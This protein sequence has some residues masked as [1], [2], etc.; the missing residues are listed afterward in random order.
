MADRDSI[1]MARALA[2]AWLGKGQ[3]S[4]N[5][6]VGAVVVQNGLIVG[7][8]FHKYAELKHAE[9]LAIDRAGEAARGATLYLNLEPCCHQGRTPP[10]CDLI[11]GSGIARIVVAISDPNPLVSGKGIRSLKAAGVEVSVG[12]MEAEA[13]KLNEAF[14]TYIT[15]HRPFVTL[16]AGVTLDGKIADSRGCSKWI[17]SEGS[18]QRVQQ[19]RFENDAVLVG[20][21]TILKDDPSLTDRSGHVRRRSLVRVV[22]DSRLRL[23]VSS[24]LIRGSSLDDIIVFCTEERDAQRERELRKAGINI[25]PAPVSG[26]KIPFD[27]VLEELGRRQI[28]SVLIEGGAEVNFEALQSGLV[29]K[30]VF[31]VAPKILGGLSS[32]PVFGGIGF[33]ELEQSVP[34]Q[35]ASVEN[36]G[37]DLMIEAYVR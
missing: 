37:P 8:G 23:P 19:L 20:I 32:L 27:F 3:T 6:M 28:I 14:E 4:P 21:G 25:I 22:L 1:Y 30:V 35:F 13:H 17:T 11:V 33:R 34:L 26:G 31:F 7:E 24:Q 29:R 12:L 10:C 16:K 15:T 2:L 9:V 5:P 18:R 36:I